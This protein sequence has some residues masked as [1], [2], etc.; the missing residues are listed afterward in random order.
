MSGLVTQKKVARSGRAEKRRLQ[1][2]SMVVPRYFHSFTYSIC[3]PFNVRG[4]ESQAKPLTKL[5]A[6]DAQHLNVKKRSHL[7]FWVNVIV[8]I[9]FLKQI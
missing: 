1:P 6:Y 7:S 5:T 3:E 2:L 8:Q 9:I 4:I